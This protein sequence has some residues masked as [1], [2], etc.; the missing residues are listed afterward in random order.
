[1]NLTSYIH[2]FM[3]FPYIFLHISHHSEDFLITAT[4]S[5][6][7]YYL[8]LRPWIKILISIQLQSFNLEFTFG[9]FSFS[10]SSSSLILNL[11]FYFFIHITFSK[12]SFSGSLWI[13]PLPQ[14]VVSLGFSQTVLNSHLLNEWWESLYISYTYIQSL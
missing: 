1:M 5:N 10:K 8:L 4:I 12:T 11:V 9:S 3:Y 7:C 13:H 6:Y 2:S 14:S